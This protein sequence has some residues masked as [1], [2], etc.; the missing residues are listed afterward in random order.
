MELSHLPLE[1]LQLIVLP[2]ADTDIQALANA[3]RA[4]CT[5]MKI[6]YNTSWFWKNRYIQLTDKTEYNIESLPLAY[7]E[8]YGWR[9]M[10]YRVLRH[11]CEG[12][13][14]CYIGPT[15]N[16]WIERP[17]QGRMLFFRASMKK[18]LW[19]HRKN[20]IVV[21]IFL[22]FNDTVMYSLNI[23]KADNSFMNCTYIV[24]S[25]VIEYY[26]DEDIIVCLTRN[27]S[28]FLNCERHG[29]SR[30]TMD[31]DGVC[32]FDD[33]FQHY[34]FKMND[35]RRFGGRELRIDIFEVSFVHHDQDIFRWKRDS[36]EML[37]LLAREVQ[38]R[39]SVCD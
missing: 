22:T 34:N 14:D 16:V 29:L 37:Q 32:T 19:L 9:K 28:V 4:L 6:F 25:D 15:G 35:Y 31:A 33:R 21:L 11:I 8:Y 30:F 18:L 24:F 38:Q 7:V 39:L 3:S 10:Y 36:K 13:K 2:L 23:I 5:V 26:A 12:D 1:L 20:N 17:E 27:G